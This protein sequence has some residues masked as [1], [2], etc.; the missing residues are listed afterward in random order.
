MRYSETLETASLHF[1]AAI[2]AEQP[3]VDHARNL[4]ATIDRDLARHGLAV[5]G[6]TDPSA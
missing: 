6:E 1:A 2:H 3:Q 5:R 4:I